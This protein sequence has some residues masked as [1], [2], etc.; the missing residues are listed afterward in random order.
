MYGNMEVKYR[1]IE[2]LIEDIKKEL[3]ILVMKVM[4]V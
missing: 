2:N 4:K 1:N 3:S